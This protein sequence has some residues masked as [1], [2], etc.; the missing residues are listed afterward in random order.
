[1]TT[2]S[3]TSGSFTINRS[4]NHPVEKVFKAFSD[5]A[6]KAKWFTGPKG[7]DALERIIEVKTGGSEVLKF[8]QVKLHYQRPVVWSTVE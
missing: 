8:K 3:P 4:F 7:G 1:M 5:P 6:T 2:A